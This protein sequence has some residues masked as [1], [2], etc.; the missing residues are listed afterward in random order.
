MKSLKTIQVLFKIGKIISKIIFI[1]CIVGFCICVTGIVSLALGAPTIKIGD[2][3]IETFIFDK[4]GASESALYLWCVVGMILCAG[5]AVLAK[6]AEC[7][8]AKEL[9][10]GTPFT[11][12]GAREMQRFGILAICLSLGTQIAVSIAHAI[13]KL[14]IK[15]LPELPDISLGSVT[16]GIMFIVMAQICKYGAEISEGKK[17]E[18]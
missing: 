6:F 7:Y 18:E 11:K 17:T 10:A 5:E 13:F 9:K 16:V 1:C 12:E 4:T 15:D 14:A 8:F 3:T 2:T